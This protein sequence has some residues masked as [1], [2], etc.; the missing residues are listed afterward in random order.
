MASLFVAWLSATPEVPNGGQWAGWSTTAI[1]IASAT[2]KEGGK[3][4]F[5]P[6]AKWRTWS[7]SMSRN[8]CSPCSRIGF[9]RNPD[10]STNTIFAG[11]DLTRIIRPTPIVVLGVTEGIRQTDAIEVFPCPVPDAEGCYFNKFFLHGIC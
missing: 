4:G 5:R 10:P 6:F 7:R 1:C 9:C 2:Y 11:A 3:P 8:R